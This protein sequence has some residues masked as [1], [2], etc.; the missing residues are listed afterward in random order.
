MKR[1]TIR[2]AAALALAAGLALQPLAYVTVAY[3]EEAVASSDES[4]T[5]EA[6]QVVEMCRLYNKWTG[7]HLYTSSTEEVAKLKLLRWKDEGIAWYA[8]A[9]SSTP[10]YRLYNPY[11]SDHH[12]TTSKDEYDKCAERGWRKEGIAW[13]S[14]DSKST[15]LYRGFNP[16]EKV[17]THHYTASSAEMSKMTEAGWR[18]EGVAW[19]GLDPNAAGSDSSSGNQGSSTTMKPSGSTSGGSSSSTGSNTDSSSPSG[20]VDYSKVTKK[21]ISRVRWHVDGFDFDDEQEARDFAAKRS[22]TYVKKAYTVHHDVVTHEELEYQDYSVWG[23]KSGMNGK[24][25]R[26]GFTTLGEVSEYIRWIEDNSEYNETGFYLLENHYKTVIDQEAYDEAVVE[27][28]VGDGQE[29]A[30]TFAT[31]AEAKAY[32][33]SVNPQV[34]RT[35]TA[36]VWV[37]ADGRQFDTE[38]DARSWAGMLVG[39]IG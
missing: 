32:C 8:P 19:Y 11:S 20:T 36:D 3:A 39:D 14:A 27:W 9:T 18:A 26:D 34:T 16:Y 38:A 31:E 5:T 24:Y 12:Y 37:T 21:T 23:A 28:V 30:K 6:S 10:V 22:A 17:G 29:G 33:D 1:N 25:Y 7:E 35:D 13:Y 4:A 2:R 15:P